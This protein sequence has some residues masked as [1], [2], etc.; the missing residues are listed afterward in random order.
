MADVSRLK[1][2]NTT[3][4]IKDTT[5]RNNTFVSVS[6]SDF[7]TLNNGF[8]IG[9]YEVMANN[10]TVY[11]HITIKANSNFTSSGSS[12]F[13]IK[14]AYCPTNSFYYGCYMGAGNWS[15]ANIGYLFIGNSG[16]VSIV[17]ING[18]YDYAIIDFIYR[19]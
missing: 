15:I 3:Y 1:V 8:S 12:P 9:H 14:T 4:D 5:A 13:T 6:Q 17:S 2:S 18:T 11:G 16:G 10:N 7:L 19:K